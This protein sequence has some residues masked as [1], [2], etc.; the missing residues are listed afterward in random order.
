MNKKIKKVIVILMMKILWMIF[1][2]KL[3]LTFL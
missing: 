1:E 3:L 2:I